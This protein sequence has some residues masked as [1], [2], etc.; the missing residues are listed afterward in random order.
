MDERNKDHEQIYYHGWEVTMPGTIKLYTIGFTHKSAR[1]FFELLLRNNVRTL[2]DI[3]LN[4]TSQLS[5]YTKMDD[6][7]F[8]LGAI[9]DIAYCHN[10]ELAPSEDLFK[11]Y[12]NKEIS[13]REFGESFR[14][15]LF[16]RMPEQK[17]KREE[18]NRACLLCSERD[19]KDCHRSIV[20]EY[21]Q[22]VYGDVEIVDL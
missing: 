15:K 11:K 7:K 8:F 4:N 6:L 20:G 2:I 9:G 22:D 19:A 17:V 13:W 14:K 21:F 3:R 1:E 18:L 5:G 12:K 16:E 10:L